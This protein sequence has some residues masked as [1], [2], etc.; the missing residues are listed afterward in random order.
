MIFLC[1]SHLSPMSVLVFFL[2]MIISAL[3]PPEWSTL[4][5][6][7]SARVLVLRCVTWFFLF[8]QK[9]PQGAPFA[10]LNKYVL[11]VCWDQFS[12]FEGVRI[13]SVPSSWFKRVAQLRKPWIRRGFNTQTNTLLSS[14]SVRELLKWMCAKAKPCKHIIYG[15]AKMLI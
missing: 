6:Y 1:A 5:D 12:H 11:V 15:A 4:S 8:H 14:S 2:S 7:P 3:T 13:D 9:E 10:G